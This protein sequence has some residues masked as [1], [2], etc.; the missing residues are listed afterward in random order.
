MSLGAEFRRVALSLGVAA[1]VLALPREAATDGAPAPAAES[2]TRSTRK[3]ML[4]VTRAV[5][6]VAAERLF[7]SGHNFGHAVPRVALGGDELHVLGSTAEVIEAVLPPGLESGTYLLVVWRGRAASQVGVFGV[8]VG[9]VGPAGPPGPQGPT[10]ATGNAG[11]A[12]DK[13]DKGD[14]GLQG[15]R[16]LPGPQGETGPPGPQ[17]SKGDPGDKGDRG[18]PGAAGRTGL[19]G[20]KGDKG[21][22]GDTGPA[23]PPGATGIADLRAFNGEIIGPLVAN[24]EYSFLGPTVTVRVTGTQ[25]LTGAASFRAAGAPEQT[26]ALG[27]CRQ[28]GSVPP[29]NFAE[30]ETLGE[31]IVTSH[32]YTVTATVSP[33]AGDWTVGLC[34]RRSSGPDFNFTAPANVN[35]WVMVTN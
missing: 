34:A 24:G 16:G 33:G 32:V 27:L 6:D 29:T 9:A 17:G 15:E 10:G 31:L 30:V 13:G 18:D 7:I 26:W 8:T 19:P 11:E 20:E 3:H 1:L 2:A 12:G 14:P 5:A 25:R 35:G 22:K 28:S 4:V 21:D 23:G